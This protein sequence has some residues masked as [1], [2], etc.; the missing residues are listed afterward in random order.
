MVR[1]VYGQPPAPEYLESQRQFAAEHDWYSVHRLDARTHFSML[2][3]PGEVASEI[4]QV[5]ALVARA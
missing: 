3:A 1:H 4:E 2:E 5:A